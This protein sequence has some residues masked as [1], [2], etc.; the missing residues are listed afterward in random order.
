MYR[1]N[2]HSLSL[3]FG[4]LAEEQGGPV[5]RRSLAADPVRVRGLRLGHLPDHPIDPGCLDRDSYPAVYII[6]SFSMFLY[7]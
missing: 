3:P 1:S 2:Q 4:P 7:V 6:R 5:A